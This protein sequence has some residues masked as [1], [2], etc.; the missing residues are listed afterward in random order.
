MSRRIRE[1]IL[2]RVFA[3]N[4]FDPEQLAALKALDEELQTA[5]TSELRDIQED[6]G[7]DVA[8]WRTIMAQYVDAKSNWLDTP[9]LTAEFYFY[10]RIIEAI[11]YFETLVDPFQAQKDLGLTSARAPIESLTAQ[12]QAVAP[13]FDAMTDKEVEA[14]LELFVLTALWG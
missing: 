9:W 7:P 5:G 10:R 14:S 6:G 11:G 3:E 13:A 12:L 1:D 4:D 2:S 8:T